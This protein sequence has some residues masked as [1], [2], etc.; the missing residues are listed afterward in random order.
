LE[1]SP[2]RDVSKEQSVTV[3][4]RCRPQSTDEVGL[5]S[6]AHVDYELK[7]I[8]VQYGPI[9]TKL[10]KAFHYDKVYGPEMQ[11]EDIFKN[12]I[13]SFVNDAI[14]G[15]TSTIFAYGQSGTGKTHLMEGDLHHTGIV[16]L[17]V[18]SIFDK[19]EK[20]DIEFIVR[21]SFLEICELFIDAQ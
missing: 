15:F 7:N 2:L 5:Q 1:T 16:T 11:N 8:E 14:D 21:V 12:G 3:F 18:Q 6:V 17:A 10:V 19:L 4:A 20:Q 13:G 9:P